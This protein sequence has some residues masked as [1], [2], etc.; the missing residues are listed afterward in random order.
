LRQYDRAIEQFQ[1]TIE[2]DPN[3]ATVYGFLERAYEAKGLYEQAV[4]AD[5]KAFALREDSSAVVAA[6]KE[7]Y[8]VYGW[9]GYWRKRLE[10]TKEQAKRNGYVGP[11]QMVLIY[12]RLGE[13]DRAFEWME[14]SYQE[15]DFWLNF[16]K[17]D[18]LLDSLRP[19][20]RFTD[21]LQR[22]GLVP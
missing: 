3:F 2:L 15:R 12:A 19:D 9:T 5:L 21:L 10:L 8:R 20:A 11:N 22:V 16:I 18:P 13:R 7:A 17:I 4:A 14:K 1:K 6:L